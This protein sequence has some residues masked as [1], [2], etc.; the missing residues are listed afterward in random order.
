MT[1]WTFYP[2]FIATAVSTVGLSRIAAREQ[3]KERP[4][5]LSELATAEQSVLTRFRNILLFCGVFF[6]ITVFGFIVPSVTHPIEVAIF[7]GLMI[8]GE[9]LAALI[10]AHSK[11][12]TIHNLLAQT[13]GLGMLGLAFIFWASLIKYSLFELAFTVVMCVLLALMVLDKKH[14]LTY[15][16]GFIFSSHFTILIAA[17]A[18]R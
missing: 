2:V 13:M 3:G 18:L 9:L 15:E 11:S 1:N 4:K 10:P 16:L 12:I 6:A 5:T 14:Y 8:G 7:G 17:I